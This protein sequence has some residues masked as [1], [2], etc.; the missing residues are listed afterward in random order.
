MTYPSYSIDVEKIIN[1][2][3]SGN[4]RDVVNFILVDPNLPHQTAKNIVYSKLEEMW[5]RGKVRLF[6][7]EQSC[8]SPV[9]EVIE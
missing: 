7:K 8:G 2:I 3:G 4:V 5:Y 6:Y 1:E 9:F